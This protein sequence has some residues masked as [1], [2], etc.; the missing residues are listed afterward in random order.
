[1][2]KAGQALLA[3]AIVAFVA[4]CGSSGSSRTAQGKVPGLGPPPKPPAR[5]SC[6]A[7][8]H[9]TRFFVT[10]YS[11]AGNQACVAWER[12]EGRLGRYWVQAPEVPPQRPECTLERN[13]EVVEVRGGGESICAH[14]TG[15]GW[16]PTKGPLEEAE[17][18]EAPTP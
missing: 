9:N 3:I 18:H 16:I 8:E 12:A 11:S 17:A 14:L 7:M 4:G 15:D 2:R 1:M 13:F 5:T 6:A 10:I